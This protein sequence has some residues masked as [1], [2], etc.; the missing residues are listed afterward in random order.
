[1]RGSL[2]R[3]DAVAKLQ[4]ALSLLLWLGVIGAGRLIAYV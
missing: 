3:P 1:V 4:A 2:A